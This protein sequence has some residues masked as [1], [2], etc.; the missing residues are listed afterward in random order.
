[1]LKLNEEKKKLE[2]MIEQNKSYKEIL[3]QSQIVDKCIIDYYCED[4]IYIVI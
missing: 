3:K 2:D 1:M 4:N